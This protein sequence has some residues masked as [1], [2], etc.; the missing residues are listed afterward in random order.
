MVRP[1]YRVLGFTVEVLAHSALFAETGTANGGVASGVPAIARRALPPDP[2]VSLVPVCGERLPRTIDQSSID[3]LGDVAFPRKSWAYLIGRYIRHPWYDYDVRIVLIDDV[4]RA[5]LVWRRVETPRGPLLRI[6]DVIG[7]GEVLA[8]SGPALR[9]A[10]GEAGC[11]YIDLVCWG[12]YAAGLEE[13]GFVSTAA[14]E[15]MILPSYFSPFESRNVP[16]E[17]AFKRGANGGARPVQLC[18]ADSDQDRPNRPAEL[19]EKKRAG[20]AADGGE[21]R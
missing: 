6:V 7:H 16:L 11:D 8:R 3:A 14:H 15:E 2:A 19:H 9:A 4:A 10:L 17:A 12:P 13:A 21:Q 5:V 18:R 20:A 1:I